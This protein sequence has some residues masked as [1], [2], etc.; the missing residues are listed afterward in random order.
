MDKLKSQFDSNFIALLPK[1][2][3]TPQ[4]IFVIACD[5]IGVNW[6]RDRFLA[7]VNSDT[8]FVIGDGVVISSDHRCKLS[9]APA[10]RLSEIRELDQSNFT[11]ALAKKLPSK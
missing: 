3:F 4:P 5:V 2:N 1:F 10:R 8:P 6:L 9:V 11:W 7:L